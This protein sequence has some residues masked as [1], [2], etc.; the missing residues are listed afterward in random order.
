[1][2]E[3]VQRESYTPVIQTQRSRS[4]GEPSLIGPSMDEKVQRESYTPVIQTQGSRSFRDEEIKRKSYTSM[5]ENQNSKY[6]GGEEVP[7]KISLSTPVIETPRSKSFGGEIPAY[8]S[9]EEV[10]RKF[11]RSTPVIET[12]R[13]KSM[14]EPMYENIEEVSRR[15]SNTPIIGSQRSKCMIEPRRSSYLPV[16]ET[17]RPKNEERYA[18][19]LSEPC[20]LRDTFKKSPTINYSYDNIE[21]PQEVLIS[22]KKDEKISIPSKEG[23]TKIPTRVLPQETFVKECSGLQYET[24]FREPTRFVC[25][26]TRSPMKRVVSNENLPIASICENEN[27][28]I[29]NICENENLPIANIYENENL[30]IANI[31]ENEKRYMK[32]TVLPNE[33]RYTET[34]KHENL[35]IS[36]IYEE[37]FY[38][39]LSNIEETLKKRDFL[40]ENYPIDLCDMEAM[41]KQKMR[42][43]DEICEIEKSLSK[44]GYE[45]IGKLYEDEYPKILLVK[46]ILGDYSYIL[47]NSDST[48]LNFPKMNNIDECLI[49][50]TC[51]K[52]SFICDDLRLEILKNINAPIEGSVFINELNM[53]MLKKY[54]SIGTNEIKYQEYSYTINGINR[55]EEYGINIDKGIIVFPLVS[56]EETLKNEKI[57]Y[58]ISSFN[59]EVSKLA[60]CKVKTKNS[61]MINIVNDLNKNHKSIEEYI[62][63]FENKYNEYHS[64]LNNLYF[65]TNDCNT[66]EEVLKKIKSLKEL[67]LKL[68]NKLSLLLDNNSI[69]NAVNDQNA[70]EVLSLVNETCSLFKNLD[71]K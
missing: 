48:K 9:D 41:R 10:Q 31:C 7:R 43:E 47:M 38:N 68:I 50:E 8:V 6:F 34:C 51:S 62:C 32:T 36:G 25:E 26:N 29:A 61:S 70:T 59:R 28:P 63:T 42:K 15:S 57:L 23:Y 24:N 30:P 55:Y 2:D 5:K 66:K 45:V 14:R 67:K 11:S 12:H 56:L 1:M 60:L 40:D 21:I 49:L 18:G 4:F 54:C 16:P 71:C 53:I 58:D 17:Q 65:S 39:P 13:C 37:N 46:T 69:M 33:R 52:K 35:P 20:D 64:K 22:M 27:L 3:E 44:S 19:V